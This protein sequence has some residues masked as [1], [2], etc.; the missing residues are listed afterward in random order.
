M[1]NLHYALDRLRGVSCKGFVL[2]VVRR[3]AIARATLR[4]MLL[5]GYVV[6]ARLNTSLAER[7]E[8]KGGCREVSFIPGRP[9]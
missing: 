6:P 8:V 4:V 1:Y 7:M 3:L 9:P 5:T 2:G